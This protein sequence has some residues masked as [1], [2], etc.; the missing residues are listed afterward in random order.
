MAFYDDLKSLAK[1]PRSKTPFLTLYLN[2][3]WDCEKQRERV[4]IFVKTRLKECLAGNGSPERGGAQAAEDDAD[5]LEH[6]V[7][8]LINREWDEGFGG[9]ALFACAELG[10]YRVVRSFLPFQEGFYCSDRPILRPA[11]EKAQEGEAVILAMVAGDMGRLL[12]FE[13]GGVKREFSFEDEEFPGRHDQGGWS[14]SRYQ[15]HVDEHLHRNLKRLSSHLVKWV[16][17]R[18][19]QAVVLSGADPLLAAFEEHLP[20]R[21]RSAIRA[22]LHID[23]NSPPDVV[24][25]ET[26]WAVA[27][28]REEDNRTAV[29][30]LLDK[31]LGMG[32]GLAGPEQVAEAAAAG[33]VHELFLDTG[34]REMGWRCTAC[35][36][37]GCRAPLGCPVC[38]GAVE[39]AELGEELIRATLA[40]DGKVVMVDGHR[41]LQDERGVGAILRYA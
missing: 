14:Q 25:E 3:R 1:L 40:T 37:L 41:G 19:L 27:R 18:G 10:A 17:E 6:Y 26:L 5:R 16:D 2:T 12:E 38:G 29:A 9:V 13:L 21:V 31:G 28:A 22:R 20:K 33:R 39:F 15:R 34:F 36:A 7:K 23:P 4:R 35:G 30:A 24:Q 11:V 32:R 8:G